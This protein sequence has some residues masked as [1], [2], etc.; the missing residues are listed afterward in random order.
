MASYITVRVNLLSRLG[1][2]IKARSNSTLSIL[3]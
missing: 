1:L 2:L 3:R